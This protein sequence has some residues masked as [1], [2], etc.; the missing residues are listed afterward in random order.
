MSKHVFILAV[1]LFHGASSAPPLL[2]WLGT[3][4]RVVIGEGASAPEREEALRICRALDP[5]DPSTRLLTDT[6][7]AAHPDQA[8]SYHLIVVGTENS[9]QV[10]RDHPSVWWRTTEYQGP[11]AFP[12][13]GLYL[14]GAGDVEGR[15]A[16]VIE[17][18]RNPYAV[19]AHDATAPGP[20]TPLTWMISLSGRFPEGVAGAVGALLDGRMLSGAVV[21]AHAR[22]TG[23]HGPFELEHRV[24]SAAPPSWALPAPIE[25]WV[26]LGWHQADGLLMGSLA[27][28]LGASPRDLWRIVFRDPTGPRTLG[29][30]LHRRNTDDEVLLCRMNSPQ[31]AAEALRALLGDLGEVR[32]TPDGKGRLREVDHSG[33]IVYG[34]TR[35]EFLAIE[36]FDSPVGRRAVESVIG[37]A[38]K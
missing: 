21:D 14:F 38:G 33:G 28:R 25:G 12:V 32:E 31:D 36:S 9:N 26:A 7:V 15:S 37:G 29:E 6:W 3:G 27:A 2:D 8:S 19:V 24:L 5:A 34:A 20:D 35:G 13:R 17:P 11:A 1:L 22:T 30:N 4:T 10:L 23:R 16:G 18:R